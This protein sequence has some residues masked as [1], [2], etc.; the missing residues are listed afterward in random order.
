MEIFAV[1]EDRVV[2]GD[3]V[4]IVAG[5]IV[6]G[7]PQVVVPPAAQYPAARAEL[8]GLCSHLRQHVFFGGGAVE[9]NASETARVFEKVDVGVD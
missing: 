6:G 5:G 2:A 8:F 4:E 9:V 1:E 7:R 3:S